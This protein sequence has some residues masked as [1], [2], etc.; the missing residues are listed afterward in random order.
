MKLKINVIHFL[1]NIQYT[2]DVGTMQEPLVYKSLS[3]LSQMFNQD[4]TKSYT[5]NCMDN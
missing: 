2:T 3:A 5:T 1:D 4:I